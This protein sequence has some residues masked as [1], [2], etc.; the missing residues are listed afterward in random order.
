MLKPELLYQ[1]TPR[2][3]STYR[4]CK[5]W[6][7]SRESCQRAARRQYHLLINNHRQ[8]NYEIVVGYRKEFF[9]QELLEQ[10]ALIKEWL[11]KHKIIA[12]HVVEITEDDFGYP[13]N[14]I[15]YHFLIDWHY[16]KRRLHNIFKDACCHAGLQ[17]T[18][19]RV[20]R[21]KLIPD[22]KTFEHKVKYILKYDKFA[23]QA[24]LFQPGTGIAKIGAIG[25]W[26]INPDGTKA[27]KKAMWKNIVAG[28][29]PN[30]S[31]MSAH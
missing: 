22:R 20:L 15:H 23:D 3:Y 26:F 30:N 8:A 24:I 29:Y 7:D 13:L 10:F 18:E 1:S 11:Q 27:N 2:C 9:V 21:P 31:A 16:S 6:T 12:F 4:L 5:S 25:R 19:H 14:H 17:P 28:W